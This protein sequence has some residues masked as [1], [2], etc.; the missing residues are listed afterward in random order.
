MENTGP[1]LKDMAVQFDEVSFSYG[2][3][4]VFRDLTTRIPRGEICG[5][6]GANGAGKTTALRMLTGL[7]KPTKGSVMV[8]GESLHRNN[9][10]KI[11]YMPQLN[12]LYQELSV[13][14][15]VHFFARMYG[16]SSREERKVAVDKVISLID[17]NDR[18]RDSVSNLSGG[19]KQ[20]VSL[21]VALV[22]SPELLVLDEPTVGLDPQ[23]RASFWDHFI[24]LANCGITIV[25]SSHTMDDANHCRRLIFLQEGHIVADGTP[26]DLRAAVGSSGATLEDAFLHYV[27]KQSQ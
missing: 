7:L 1:I 17:L 16:I 14:E 8:L 12:S 10:D 25:V 24:S 2:R 26:E 22:H 27:L 4:E 18:R 21:A 20:R 9:R 6:L 19:M 23:L 3:Q 11:G 5:I 15:N 13:E